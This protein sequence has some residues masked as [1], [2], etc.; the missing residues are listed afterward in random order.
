VILRSETLHRALAPFGALG[1]LAFALLGCASSE[2]MRAK[3]AD[4]QAAAE[5]QDDAKC[6]AG[7]PPGSAAYEDCRKTQ[8][9][10]RAEQA[11]AQ[12]RRQESFQRALGE[13]STSG[14]VN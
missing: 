2:Q 1:L 13:G 4:A 3:Q 7:A 10:A 5:E 14:P 6:R 12:A 11:A 8:A 9:K